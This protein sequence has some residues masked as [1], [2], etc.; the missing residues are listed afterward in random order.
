MTF[1]SEADISAAWSALDQMYSAMPTNPV[2]RGARAAAEWTT[3]QRVVSPIVQVTRPADLQNVRM[4]SVEAGRL[5]LACDVSDP[6]RAQYARGADR[7]LQW[8]IGSAELPAW[9]SASMAMPRSR[10]S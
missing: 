9:I 2:I 5:E 10:A 8:W 3:G 1:H 7:W 4:E 6:A